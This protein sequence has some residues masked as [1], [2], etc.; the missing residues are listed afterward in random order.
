MH[1]AALLQSV[2]STKRPYNL[3]VLSFGFVSHR[4]LLRLGQLSSKCNR[5]T[6]NFTGNLSTCPPGC[7]FIMHQVTS[8]QP[9][10]STNYVAC[11]LTQE[12]ITRALG[13]H[14]VA[15]CPGS[16]LESYMSCVVD[17]EDFMPSAATLSV[18]SSSSLS[19]DDI[20]AL[21]RDACNAKPV[22]GKGLQG[23]GCTLV[24]AAP[25]D[26]QG[27]HCVPKAW[28][29]DTVG[30]LVQILAAG[31]PTAHNWAWLAGNC[32]RDLVSRVSAPTPGDTV[33]SRSGWLLLAG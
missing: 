22:N 20:T 29:N 1:Y 26:K 25:G 23:Q 3:R 19:P 28:S 15:A 24:P 10:A 11:Q 16:R 4:T 32:G 2:S 5:A 17:E 33:T 30:T 9:G 27:S 7:S 14:F 18:S 6:A 21:K 8:S 12:D 13:A 31:T